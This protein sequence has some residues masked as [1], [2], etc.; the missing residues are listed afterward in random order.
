MNKLLIEIVSLATACITLTPYN[1]HESKQV[2]VSHFHA[3]SSPRSYLAITNG[4]LKSSLS[5][6]AS[7]QH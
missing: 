6:S 3:C 4:S 7:F 5:F 2:L 1:L